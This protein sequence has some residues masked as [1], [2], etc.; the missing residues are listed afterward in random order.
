MNA[1]PQTVDVHRASIPEVAVTTSIPEGWH[2]ELRDADPA[3]VAA[4]TEADAGP[5]GDNL[6][7]SIERIPD[8]MPAHLAAI[9]AA[10]S[11]QQHFT[12]PDLLVIDDRPFEL[13]STP[14]WFRAISFTAENHVSVV[15]RQVMAVVGD[16]L[17]TIILTT[18]PFRDREAAAIFSSSIAATRVTVQDRG[19]R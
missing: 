14:A 9:R 16:V 17:V 13:D 5:F 11:V 1:A 18:L 10:S 15:S 12:V 19:Q 8:E 3:F 6:I 7:I 2:T 4:M